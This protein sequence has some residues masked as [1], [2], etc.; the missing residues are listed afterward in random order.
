MIDNHC[1]LLFHFKLDQEAWSE[2]CDL[3]ISEHDYAKA[4]FCAE[5]LL[6]ITPHNHLNHERYASICYSQGDYEKARTYYFST[7]KFNPD[8]MRALYGILLTSTNMKSK[9]M[10]ETNNKI[11][12]EQILQK[13]QETI[14]ELVPF[15]DKTLKN[16]VSP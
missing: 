10:T 12:I 15:V 14:P 7:L 9:S 6:L 8:N 13:Y 5:E 16:L 4:A 3:Y 2:L 1:R 11:I